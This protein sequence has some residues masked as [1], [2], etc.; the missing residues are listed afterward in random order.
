MN[1]ITCDCG[2]SMQLPGQY[3]GK[4]VQCRQCGQAFSVA[5]GQDEIGDVAD[6]PRLTIVAGQQRV[7]EK[8]MLAGTQPITFGKS[9]DVNLQLDHPTV[10][11]RHGRLVPRDGAWVIEDTGSTNGVAVNGVAVTSHELSRGDTVKIGNFFMAFSAPAMEEMLAAAPA[12]SD[13]AQ[14]GVPL[15][16]LD[17]FDDEAQDGDFQL[18]K[19]PEQVRAEKARRAP[20]AGEKPCIACD[21]LLP[22]V[23]EVCT[24][25]GTKLKSGRP[26]VTSVGLDVDEL[27]TNAHTIISPVSWLGWFGLYPF[28]SDAGGSRKPIAIWAITILTVLVSFWYF[29]V[30]ETPAMQ[31]HKNLMLWPADPGEPDAQ[32][33]QML[34]DFTAFG[35][36]QAFDRKLKELEAAKAAEKRESFGIESLTQGPND[37]L[38]LEAHR[39]LEPRQRAVGEFHGYQLLTHALLHG[40]FMH[41]AGNLLFMWVFGSRVNALVG[42]AATAVIYPALAIFAGIAH[43]ISTA[44]DQPV[45]MLGASG[46]IMG[47]A[48][49]YFVLFPVQHVHMAIWLRFFWKLW[50]KMFAVRGFWVL[51]FYISQDI[52]FSSL[53]AETGTAHWA[54]LGGFI[55]G[56]TI[57]TML[58]V[59]RI[60]NV[61]GDL[62]SV[63]LGR[64]AWPLLGRPGERQKRPA[65]CWNAFTPKPPAA[66]ARAD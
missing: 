44:G 7:D 11:R 22:E 33:L 49:M 41:L 26:L 5:A 36:E 59:L 8:I 4:R 27:Y 13:G 37:E 6:L 15:I 55:A 62:L 56:M 50:L 31:T 25:C 34:Y 19:L 2:K 9:P 45:P 53:G 58:L 48:G 1:R 64:H 60:V 57:A 65:V 51:L 46:A 32:R 42:S 21:A 12:V 52:L 20:K 47:L 30:D 39:A 14:T 23:S 3:L 43:M 29:T 28:A 61:Q 66:A 24:W 40:S 16:D 10:S 18:A 17:G 38:V 63:T 35:D 54:H